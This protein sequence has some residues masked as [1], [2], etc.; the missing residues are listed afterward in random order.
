MLAGD[1]VCQAMR[2]GL[3]VMVVGIASDRKSVKTIN[4]G[5][6]QIGPIAAIDLPG[7]IL[8][9][10][11]ITLTPRQ[12]EREMLR[13]MVDAIETAMRIYLAIQ[14]EVDK[15]SQAVKLNQDGKPKMRRRRMSKEEK[16]G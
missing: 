4:S 2:V 1:L 15:A 10:L 13:V 5:R 12:W 11:A 9:L 6:L 16:N 7:D 8:R 14:A 3:D